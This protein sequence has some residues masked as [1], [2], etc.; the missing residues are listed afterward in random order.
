MENGQ[1]WIGLK[2][3]WF[4]YRVIMKVKSEESAKV[5]FLK[6]YRLKSPTAKFKILMQV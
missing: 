2:F 3:A 5:F 6:T 1:K 4:L